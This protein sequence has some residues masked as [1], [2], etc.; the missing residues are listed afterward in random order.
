MNTILATFA[1]R[2]KKQVYHVTMNTLE[3]NAGEWYIAVNGSKVYSEPLHEGPY[4]PNT[5]DKARSILKKYLK[6]AKP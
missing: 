2:Y 5:E 3:G 1:I 4:D 6:I